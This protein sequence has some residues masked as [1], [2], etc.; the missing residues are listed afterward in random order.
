MVVVVKVP[1][2]VPVYSVK[3][4]D[5]DVESDTLRFFRGR[6]C[7][8]RRGCRGGVEYKRVV[9]IVTVAAVVTSK[10]LTRFVDIAATTTTTTTKQT[11]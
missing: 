2:L 10:A 3:N 6:F 5:E 9:V 4:G 8:L 11:L 1:S 7:K